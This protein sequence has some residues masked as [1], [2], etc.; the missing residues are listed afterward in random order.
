M[1]FLYFMELSLSFRDLGK[2][3][4]HRLIFSNK[5]FHKSTIPNGKIVKTAFIFYDKTA[6]VMFSF[7]CKNTNKFYCD[8][9]LLRPPHRFNMAYQLPPIQ[10]GF[11]TICIW[12][13]TNA[14]GYE[15]TLYAWYGA[16]KP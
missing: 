10:C 15:T 4:K 8:F 16:D 9:S 3:W 14:Y 1:V 11:I 6:K 13:N 12:I 2:F 7:E 5:L